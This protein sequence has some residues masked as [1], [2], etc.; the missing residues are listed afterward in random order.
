MLP[1]TLYMDQWQIPELG[2]FCNHPE[3][4]CPSVYP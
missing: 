1:G 3:P 2:H 4:L